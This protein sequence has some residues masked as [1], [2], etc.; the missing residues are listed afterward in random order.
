MIYKIQGTI[1]FR[2]DDG[3][4]WLDDDSNVALTATTSRLLKFLLDHRERVVYRDEI[5]EKVWDA[6]GLRT[7][8]H[9]LNKYISD[10]RA[11][12]RNM[13]CPEEVIVTVPKI[14]F[15][16]SESILIEIVDNSTPAVGSE[17]NT[18]NDDLLGNSSEDK[19]KFKSSK[20]VVKNASYAFLAL[21][22]LVLLLLSVKSDFYRQLFSADQD[23]VYYLGD[24]DS[25]P[26]RSFS[27][28]PGEQKQKMMDLAQQLVAKQGMHCSGNGV[29]YFSVSES[30]LK[31]YEGRGF[32]AHCLYSNAKKKY[33][34]SCENYYR[35]DYEITK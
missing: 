28:I 15:R 7:S 18:G 3:L 13:G 25:C 22:T 5:L 29:F 14:G 34:Y 35:P 6:H 9:S 19:G 11:V 32:L 21:C 4:V 16:V 24:I 33:F 10:L 26:V 2:S 12:F 17:S 1:H 20:G 8:S 30:V 27:A 23:E 31:G